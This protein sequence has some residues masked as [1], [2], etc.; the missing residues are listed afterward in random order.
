MHPG[1]LIDG[2]NGRYEIQQ[3]VVRGQLSAVYRARD[4]IT[5]DTVAVKATRKGADDNI[6]ERLRLEC[7]VLSKLDHPNIAK[8]YDF[9]EDATNCYL[10]PGVDV[11]FPPNAFLCGRAG[12]ATCGTGMTPPDS[13]CTI[14]ALAAANAQGVG[15]CN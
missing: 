15:I 13:V 7:S 3:R 5:G 11:T 9:S 10:V 2:A 8:F 6:A 12:L 1:D 14:N 4:L